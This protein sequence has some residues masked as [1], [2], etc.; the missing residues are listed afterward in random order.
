MTFTAELKDAFTTHPTSKEVYVNELG[1]WYF[2]NKG[3]PASFGDYQSYSLDEVV[4][5]E[6]TP[7]ETPTEETNTKKTKK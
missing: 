1:Q 2:D 3:V 4:A 6:T 5:S 7:T